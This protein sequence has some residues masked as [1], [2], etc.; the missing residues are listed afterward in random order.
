MITMAQAFKPANTGSSMLYLLLSFPLGVLYF[1]FVVTA[2][3][4]GLGT[5]VIWV[6]IPILVLLT[7]GLW[8]IASLERDLAA[9]LLHIDIPSAQKFRP[10]GLTWP[11]RFRQR[12]FSGLTWRTLMYTLVIKFPLGIISFVLVVTL[13]L[14]A[15]GL[16]LEPLVYLINV[17]VDGIVYAASG[18]GNSILPFFVTIVN[19]QFDPIMFMRSFIGVPVGFVLWCV[20]AYLLNG[21]AHM[22]GEL[23]RA[24]LCPGANYNT[25]PRDERAEV[26]YSSGYV[27]GYQ[28]APRD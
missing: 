1:V 15:L 27:Q 4:L 25:R 20:A 2:L 24:M 16:L 22:Q 21:L 10:D 19:G 12:V 6:G 13:P 3:S 17:F 28:G 18:H 23:V 26:M 14:L 9:S 7:M 5:I 8:G 11:Q